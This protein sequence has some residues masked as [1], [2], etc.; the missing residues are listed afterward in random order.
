MCEAGAWAPGHWAVLIGGSPSCMAVPGAAAT[1]EMGNLSLPARSVLAVYAPGVYRD[2][3]P[4]P[5]L[6]E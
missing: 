4:H 3:G 2:L 6:G 1:C 5:A